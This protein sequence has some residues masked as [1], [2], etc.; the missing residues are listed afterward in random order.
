MISGLLYCSPQVNWSDGLVYLV[1]FFHL[2]Q[3]S[4][5]DDF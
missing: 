4:Q 2:A 3:V 1:S 5:S